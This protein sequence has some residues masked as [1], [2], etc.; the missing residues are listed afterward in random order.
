MLP[1]VLWK[2]FIHLRNG[3]QTK[4]PRK[5][6][7]FRDW[8]I[9]IRFS[10]LEESFRFWDFEIRIELFIR[11]ME[12]VG[13][14]YFRREIRS[15]NAHSITMQ[16]SAA[17]KLHRSNLNIVDAENY[18]IAKCGECSIQISKKKLLHFPF[19]MPSEHNCIAGIRK[20]LNSWRRWLWVE[21][22]EIFSS[23]FWSFQDSNKSIRASTRVHKSYDLI[24]SFAGFIQ[25]NPVSNEWIRNDDK[26]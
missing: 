23:K 11:S 21:I 4:P 25:E 6:K 17:L 9:T 18:Y 8:K 19:K 26:K 15:W 5:W 14:I 22:F 2:V 10:F 24:R 1:Q 7:L 13:G 12:W 3:F 20:M 16:T